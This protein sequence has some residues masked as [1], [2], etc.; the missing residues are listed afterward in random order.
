MYQKAINLIDTGGECLL[1]KCLKLTEGQKLSGYIDIDFSKHIMISKE[2]EKVIKKHLSERFSE[3]DAKIYW[4][5]VL[6]QYALFLLDL[7]DLG[8]KKSRH[9]EPGGTYDCISI[10]AYYEGRTIQQKRRGALSF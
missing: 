3:D 1:Q 5:K 10:F 2:M 6:Q 4:N 8:K 9:N 7:P